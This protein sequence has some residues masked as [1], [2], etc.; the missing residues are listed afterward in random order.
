LTFFALKHYMQR[1]AILVLI[2]SRFD[3]VGQDFLPGFLK[4]WP[5]ARVTEQLQNTQLAVA[6]GLTTRSLDLL[7]AD[8][9]A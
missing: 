1:L 9:Q 4:Q 2:G 5:P 7:R 8:A 3:S 6:Q